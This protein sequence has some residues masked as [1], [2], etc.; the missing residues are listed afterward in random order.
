MML[1][2]LLRSGKI[3]SIFRSYAAG[4]AVDVLLS[5]SSADSVSSSSMLGRISMV[6]SAVVTTLFF[7]E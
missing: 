1:Q 6:S 2:C 5:S 4:E 7:L 3:P